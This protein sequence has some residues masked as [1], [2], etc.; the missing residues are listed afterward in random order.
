MSQGLSPPGPQSP[1]CYAE[2]PLGG[3]ALGPVRATFL[4]LLEVP[5][6]HLVQ[7]SPSPT[8]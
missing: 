5:G 1:G 2:P 3:P 8:S 4:G 6:A 7:V